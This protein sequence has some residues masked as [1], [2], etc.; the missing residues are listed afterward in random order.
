ML[1]KTQNNA[2]TALA[3]VWAKLRLDS[4][5]WR[6][7]YTY[8]NVKGDFKPL[9]TLALAPKP[10]LPYAS[11]DRDRHTIYGVFHGMG[12]QYCA[13]NGHILRATHDSI[14]QGILIPTDV[15]KLAHTLGIKE[16]S[17][18]ADAVYLESED[19][20]ILIPRNG[21]FVPYGRVI[22]TTFLHITDRPHVEHVPQGVKSCMEHIAVTTVADFQP[23]RPFDVKL[24]KI[25][26]K[27]IKSLRVLGNARLGAHIIKDADAQEIRMIMPL[28]IYDKG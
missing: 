22:P 8:E 17:Y 19:V 14:I 4:D 5:E 3:K 24:W 9:G 25:V 6:I 16:F 2:V 21:N 11:T 13:T 15:F 10:Y 23:V 28:R 18:S 12:G 27:G 1:N 26:T 7:G 20:Q